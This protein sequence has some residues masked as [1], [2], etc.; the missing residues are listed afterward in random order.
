MYQENRRGDLILSL[1]RLQ[2]PYIITDIHHYEIDAIIK[3]E[4]Q[5]IIVNGSIRLA[6]IAQKRN[7]NPGSFLNENF[8]YDVWFHHYNNF[9]LNKDAIFCTIADAK[10]HQEEF[11]IRP[12]LDDKSFDGKVF[13][14]KEFLKFQ[15]NCL[16]GLPGMPKPET[17]ILICK[18]QKKIGQEHR[19][20]IVDGKI[21][22]SSRY[23]LSGQPNFQEGA[24]DY[25]L[26]F[27]QNI[28]NKWQ[29]AKAFVLD[30]FISSENIG[31]IE[32]GGICYAGLYQAN[33]M[34]LV[35]ALDN[36]SLEPI[37]NTKL[38]IQNKY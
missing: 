23:K 38:E 1:E 32:V 30:T 10:I 24:D 15:Q 16:Q 18:T 26:D 3:D 28:I 8:S 9:L 21:I 5:P 22:T 19:H 20:Y 13:Q 29:P 7:W 37:S 2:I 34:K 4:K 36:I 35:Y 6:K 11:F 31:I 17:K 14:K 25:I 12:I 33:I 27:V